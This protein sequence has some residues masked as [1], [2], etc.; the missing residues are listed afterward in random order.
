MWLSSTGCLLSTAFSI[1]AT[2]ALPKRILDQ[3]YTTSRPI[4]TIVEFHTHKPLSLVS[5]IL[6]IN[7]YM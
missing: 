3:A 2:P 6:K 5:L 4:K 1:P 7:F